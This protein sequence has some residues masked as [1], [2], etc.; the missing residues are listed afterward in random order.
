MEWGRGLRAAF[1][2]GFLLLVALITLFLGKPLF[3]DQ[4]LLAADLLFQFD[5]L[6]QPLAPAD[7]TVPANQVLSDQVFEFYPW[8]KFMRHEL[9]QGR[10]PL[11]NPY[12]NSGHPLLANAQSAL[13]D[14]F[15]VVALLWP[16]TMSFVMVAFLRLLCA[17]TFTLL[18]ALELGQSRVAAY[19]AMVVFTFAGP[20]IV[21]ILYPKA[22]VLVWLPALLF[23]SARLIRTGKWRY[24]TWLGLVM[25]AQLVGGHPETSLY[26][27]LLWVAFSGYWLWLRVRT[28][29]EQGGI[30]RRSLV[31][32]GVAGVLGLGVG[33]IQWLPVAEALWQSEILAARSQTALTWQSLFLQW[34]DWL[35]ALTLLMPNFFGNP[36][37]ADYWYPYSNYTE[38]TIFV[39]VLPLALALLVY[40][41]KGKTRQV[42]FF[43]TLGVIS[44]G[45]ALRLPGFTLLAEMPGLSVTNSGRLRG[46]FM[47]VVALLAGYGLDLV[48]QNL[49]NGPAGDARDARLL[50]R[51]V[52]ALGVLATLVAAAAYVLVTILHDQ[53]VEMGRIQAEAAQG[54]PFFFRSLAEYATLAQARVDQMTASFH[55]ANWTMYGPL[56]LAV[57]LVAV[58][59]GVRRII[60][61]PHQRAQIFS[62][63]ILALVIG[64]LWLFG[65]DYNPTV[66]PEE[67]YPT[68]TL[69]D[70]LLQED[71]PTASD[72]YRVM[73][74]RLTLI[75]NTSMVFGL[76]DIRGYDPIAPRRYME[77]M[78]RLA[79]ASRV[80]HHL[81]FTAAD[82]PLLD[83][84]NVRYAFATGELA[85][86]WTPVQTSDGVT[87]YA[88]TEAMPRAFMVYTS[89]VAQ[90]PSESLE[91]TLAPD[92]DFRHQV[93]LEGIEEAAN[94]SPPGLSPQIKSTQDAPGV[95]TVEV[96]SAVAGILVMSDPYTSGWVATV[97]GVAARIL[98]AN[99]AFR[100]VQVPAGE[101]TVRLEY[102]PLSFTVGAWGSG[103]SLLLIVASLA[104]AFCTKVLSS[105]QS[106]YKAGAV[107][108]FAQVRSG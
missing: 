107:Q 20:Q 48:R 91:M 97:D 8:K 62:V 96:A 94:Q 29:P 39:G 53:L 1:F 21:W 52:V 86:R 106:P 19:V 30:A 37:H 95:M 73:G 57:T 79:G 41:V 9:A 7:F 61:P 6:W 89:R 93:V 81:L 100:A 49:L 55:P 65:F 56:I 24:V 33:A 104:H 63:A 25:G 99:H 46:L 59:I 84:L 36:R 5:P 58:G 83:F 101:H 14:P 45:M 88:N 27:V 38:Q 72:P 18:L 32:L 80:G 11:W 92:F 74:T 43:T 75:P 15:N 108:E 28:M 68:P 40:F 12:V 78:S 67:V 60:H 50:T 31:Q 54:N 70:F 4:P 34:R 69:V 64:E 76:E 22:S 47:L 3:T 105:I 82:A 26:L 44:L 77:L 87:L 16:L 71:A 23:L 35:A 103:L 2:Q 42:A 102:R 51:L 90:S 10:L 66:A 17:G 13:F 85:G 98:I